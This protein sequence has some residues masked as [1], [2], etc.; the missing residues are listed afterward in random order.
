M[1]VSRE[2][3]EERRRERNVARA[4]PDKQQKLKRNQERDISEV[5]ALGLPDTKARNNETRFDE[6]LFNSQTVNY[7]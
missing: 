6:R 3:Q 7:C 5:I 2:R 4:A 1:F